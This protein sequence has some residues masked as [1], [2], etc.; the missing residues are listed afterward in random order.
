MGT[1]TAAEHDAE[2]VEIVFALTTA[3]FLA[4]LVGGVAIA[5]TVALR[6]PDTVLMAGA[7][8][9]ALV[10]TARLL[11]VMTAWRRRAHAGTGPAQPSHPGRT[12]PVS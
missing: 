5:A 8:L 9:A 12:R 7:G 6:L 2:T 10:F 1:R 4:A 3:A 11:K